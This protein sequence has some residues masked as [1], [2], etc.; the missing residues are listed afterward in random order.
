MINFHFFPKWL[1]Y[2]LIFPKSWALGPTLEG[3]RKSLMF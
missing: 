2:V 1:I 3:I